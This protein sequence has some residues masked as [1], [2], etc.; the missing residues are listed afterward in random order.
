MES[1]KEV[2]IKEV[3]KIMERRKREGEKDGKR[4]KRR[5]RKKIS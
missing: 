1:E 3:K 2:K 4:D 5:E